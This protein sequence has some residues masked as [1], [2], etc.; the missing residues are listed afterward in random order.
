LPPSYE[1]DQ[2]PVHDAIRELA[3]FK[4][5]YGSSTYRPKVEQMFADVQQRLVDHELYVARFYLD[6]NHPVAAIWRLE[7]VK[8][9]YPSAKRDADVLLLLGQ[10]YLKQDKA[11]EARDTFRRLTIEHSDKYQAR[12][13]QLYLDYIARRFPNLPKPKALPP[14]QFQ[15]PTLQT[16]EEEEPVA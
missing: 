15:L 13:A 6:R 7:Y 2:G 12:Q 1:K 9:H 11:I 14:R 3:S 10:V 4:N 16:P 8:D 5:K